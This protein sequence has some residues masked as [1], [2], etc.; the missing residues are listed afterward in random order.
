MSFENVIGNQS[1]KQLLSHCL[2]ASNLLHSYMFVGIEGIGKCLLAKEFAKLIL[3]TVQDLSNH[4]DFMMIRPEDNK[5]I[6]IEQIRYLQEKIA[7]KPIVSDRKV[8]I[9]DNSDTMT[10][11]AQNCLLKTLEEPPQYAIIILILS[12]ETRILTTIKS[13]CTKLS[14]QPLSQAEIKQCLSIQHLDIPNETILKVCSGSIGKYLQ[15]QDEISHYEQIDSIFE[16]IEQVD[17]IDVWKNSD[18]LYQSK[19]SIHHLLEYMNICLFDKL[20]Q[21]NDMRYGQC[22]EIIEQTKKKLN[23]NAN[24]DMCIDNLLL[25][26]WEEFHEEYRWS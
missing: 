11:D 4:P 3:D 15:M 16:Q 13:R 6:K 8:Y 26:I 1:I 17:M 21:T 20:K 5:S 12:N 25:K 22:I 10:V 2:D 23:A 7:E 14:F 24:Y 19:D 18:V 9:L